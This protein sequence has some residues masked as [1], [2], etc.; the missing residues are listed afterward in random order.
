M[1]EVGLKH[2]ECI[3]DLARWVRR[4]GNARALSFLL[5]A[6]ACWLPSF[7]RLAVAGVGS[8]TVCPLCRDNA[9]DTNAHALHDCAATAAARADSWSRAG[10]LIMSH[11]YSGFDIHGAVNLASDWATSLTPLLCREAADHG[12][13]YGRQRHVVSRRIQE[14]VMA[15]RELGSIDVAVEAF[16][17]ALRVGR[18]HVVDSSALSAEARDL[19]CRC[20]RLDEDWCDDFI[21]HALTTNT[22]RW[23]SD[24]QRN[25]R[26]GA[27]GA[28]TPTGNA[29]LAC[30]R[31]KALIRSSLRGMLTDGPQLTPMRFAVALAPRR[32]RL[33]TL[34]QEMPG[35]HDL[36][37]I[38]DCRVILVQ[39]AAAER[40]DG[41]E[42]IPLASRYPSVVLPAPLQMRFGS[43]VFARQSRGDSHTD[44][45][46]IS[47]P[48]LP[49]ALRA[50]HWF[51]PQI[52]PSDS[53]FGADDRETRSKAVRRALAAVDRFSRPAGFLG[54][55]PPALADVL[56]CPPRDDGVP[57]LCDAK[58]AE[59]LCNDI[60][61]CLFWSAFHSWSMRCHLLRTWHSSVASA[62]EFR[63]FARLFSGAAPRFR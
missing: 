5:R 59:A 46:D 23:V 31:A 3:D 4:L 33:L 51:I 47:S 9:E 38:D 55:I 53:Y 43:P 57:L 62:G 29:L 19:L 52:P 2:L 35:F 32:M 45:F 26:V 39:N 21:T 41:A 24:R 18:N 50:F 28:G 6:L 44:V 7:H 49:A 36:G 61:G 25:I 15:T 54:V 14:V 13:F 16:R 22:A 48:R 56:R 1:A 60:R 37:R 8:R 10:A 12:L 17:K 11:R 58:E 27:T 63:A 20:L 34:L 30:R 42:L 40:T